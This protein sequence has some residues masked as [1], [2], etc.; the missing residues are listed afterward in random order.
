[1]MF[2]RED[3]EAQLI[4]AMPGKWFLLFEA[5]LNVIQLQFQCYKHV[6]GFSFS[7][8]DHADPT[9][10]VVPPLSL[11]VTAGQSLVL[12]CE[13]SSDSSLN[14]KFKW[15][16][17][18]KAID[19]SKQEHFEMIGKVFILEGSRATLA[20]KWE[21][22]GGGG[23]RQAV[24][25]S[26]STNIFTL[27]V[28]LRSQTQRSAA[29]AHKLD[30]PN[31]ITD[32]IPTSKRFFSSFHYVFSMFLPAA[33]PSAATSPLSLWQTWKYQRWHFTLTFF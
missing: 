9:R 16:F 25:T 6:T 13:V 29:P 31:L 7:C 5:D 17:N 32:K 1:M 18:G 3:V 10:I 24:S 21:G 22:G 20:S 27:F 23:S 8:S 26:G 4:A 15:F 2:W 12:P 11:D 30:L 19:F 28:R 14:P 33:R